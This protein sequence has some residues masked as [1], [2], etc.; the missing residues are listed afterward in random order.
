M[1]QASVGAALHIEPAVALDLAWDGQLLVVT[2]ETSLDPATTYQLSIGTEALDLEGRPLTR[3]LQI[4]FTTIDPPKA[5][6]QVVAAPPEPAPVPP[7]ATAR[8]PGTATAEPR[9]SATAQRREPT[10]IATA[11]GGVQYAR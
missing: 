8:P 11:R 5:I 6:G 2:P 1:E 7:A 4:R 3:P 9:P 10:A